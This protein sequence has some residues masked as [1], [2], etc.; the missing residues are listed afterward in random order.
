M[1][2][3]ISKARIQHGEEVRLPVHIF[4]L[5]KGDKKITVFKQYHRENE[6]GNKEKDKG[7]R[8]HSTEN[9]AMKNVYL[10]VA[11]LNEK[12]SNRVIRGYHKCRDQITD[13]FKERYP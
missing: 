8:F 3:K 7:D 1:V 9:S 13:M 4:Q 10:R 11:E 5:S 6:Q 12:G 2:F